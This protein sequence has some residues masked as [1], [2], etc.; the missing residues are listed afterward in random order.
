MPAGKLLPQKWNGEGLLGGWRRGFLLL[1]HF[2]VPLGV[3]AQNPSAQ[4][5][6]ELPGIV[7]TGNTGSAIS[8]DVQ[9]AKQILE[10]Y[11]GA[12]SLV[13]PHD[14]SLG[15]GSYLEDYLG[16]EPGVFIQSAQGSEDV[17]AS[18]RGSGV[19]DD[20]VAGLEILIDGI[21]LN[22]ADGEAYLQDFDLNSVK[23]A[24]V[25]RGADAL[26]YGSITLGG[27]INLVTFTGRDVGPLTMRL[28]VGSF[29]FTE[30]KLISGW[31]DGPIDGYVSILNHTLEGFRDW[32]QENYQKIFASIGYKIGNSA[33]NR[34][35]F[36]FGRLDQNNPTALTKE[37]LYADPQQTEPEAIQEKW[38]TS[39]IYER[40][41]DRFVAK[42][43][44]WQLQLGASWNH[45]Q[46]TQFQEYDPSTELG[47]QRYYSDDF[48]AEIAFTS[49][50]DILGAKNRFVIGFLPTFEKESDAWYANTNG[51]IGHL[52]SG[53]QTWS[54]NIPFY[55]ENRHYFLKGFLL[56]T[57]FQAVFV[58][59]QYH[60]NTASLTMGNQSTHENFYAFNPKLGLA[61]EWNDG[62]IAYVNVSRSFQPPSFDESLS[63][64]ANGGE[65]FNRLEAQTGITL[66][67]GTR[68][69]VGP[70]SWDFA[71]YRSWLRDELLGL[72]NN[73]GV[74]LGTVNAPKTIHQGI[75]FGAEV[76]LAHSLLA[77]NADPNKTDRIVLKQSY[78]WSDF[79]FQNYA[80]YGNNKIAG[81]PGQFYKAELRYEHPGGFYFGTNVEWSIKKYPVD[82]ANT[83]FAH[84]YALLG[85]RT[86]YKTNN[87]FESFFEAKNLANKI[88]AASVSPIADARIGGDPNSFNP[89]NG[90]AFY[91]GVSWSW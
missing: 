72:N 11:P 81:T 44:E 59:R 17:R 19:Q 68:G 29:G 18:I 70:V 86:G 91:G 80:V 77:R 78:T 23:Y 46:Q 82:E 45:R 83:L 33:E 26:R 3:S 6:Y 71:I 76:E 8:P 87:G 64:Q 22:Q 9:T 24:E 74:P 40:V 62:C 79:Y 85:I 35:Y 21:P 50:A 30:E 1:I 60:D 32:S 75:E 37:E 67:L 34:V 53:D 48:G 16:F 12:T 47:T 52:L 31:S 28:S 7:V 58:Q 49:T 73:Q 43:D 20:N 61:Y 57:G 36:F 56:L 66:E 2:L 15:R 13:T 38:N 42:G 63:V 88:Y 25:F 51:T 69:E 39:W 65:T 55:V 84:P 90:R 27:A 10:S 4:A 54:A 14:F 89:G 5:P 41:L